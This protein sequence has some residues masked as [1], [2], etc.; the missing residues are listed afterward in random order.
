MSLNLI[1]LTNF[2]LQLYYSNTKDIQLYCK[3]FKFYDGK[4]FER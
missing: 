2:K 4:A 3:E 1:L